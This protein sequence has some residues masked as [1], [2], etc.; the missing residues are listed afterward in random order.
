MDSETELPHSWTASEWTA[1]TI[2][3][4]Y[5]ELNENL[6]NKGTLKIIDLPSG[7]T[8]TDYVDAMDNSTITTVWA[9][10]STPY[11]Y[12]IYDVRKR[13]DNNAYIVAYKTDQTISVNRKSGGKWIG[14]K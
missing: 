9:T 13:T 1:T 14:W 12:C 5:T 2:L 7:T 11:A 6:G 4:L 3:D 10:E 8:I